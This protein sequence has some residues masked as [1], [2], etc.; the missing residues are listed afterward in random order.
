VC[1]GCG[2]PRN[3]VW[4]TGKV[5]KGGNGYVPPTDHIVNVTFIGL[6]I[7][8]VSGK[9]LSSSEPFWAEVDQ[10][11]GTFSVPGPDGRGIPPGKYRV[12]VTQKLTRE[13]FNAANPKPKKGVN[14]E[15]DTLG[16]RFGP[17]TSPFVR[18]VK[19][20]GEVTIDLDKPSG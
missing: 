6:E 2:E 5:L 9:A 19:T 1:P 18:E 20:G 4:V 12:A 15:K 8:D 7:Q 17:D 16:N 3:T 13:A 11:N 10:T 14:R